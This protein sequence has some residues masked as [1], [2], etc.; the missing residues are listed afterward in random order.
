VKAAELIRQGRAREALEALQ[1]EVR[2]DASNAKHRVFLFQLLCVLGQWERALQQLDVAGQLDPANLLMCQMYRQALAC[3]AVRREVFAGQR[4]P[5]VMGEPEEWVALLL[6]AALLSG[7]GKHEQ[8]APLRER[9]FEAAPAVAGT[10]YVETGEPAPERPAG[11]DPSPRPTVAHAF[12]W[13]ADADMRLGPMVEAIV[14]GK[15]YWVPWS[16]V[17]KVEID[18]PTDLRD[19]VWIPATFTWSAGGASV[20]LIPARY[21]G[22]EGTADD[23]LLLSRRTDFT[24]P[25]P[26][27]NVCLGQRLLTTDA[28]EFGLLQARRVTL[29]AQ[30]DGDSGEEGAG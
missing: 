21:P 29:G 24:E 22:T 5:M 14:E 9:A 20:G 3:E 30:D 16:R 13:L 26:G 8:A 25:A 27:L 7:Q 19:K 2:A 17:R 6:Q 1:A 11:G 10:I 12:E 18:A 28:G 4:S 15:Y 23:A